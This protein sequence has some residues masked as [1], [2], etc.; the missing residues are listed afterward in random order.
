MSQEIHS[1]RVCVSIYGD[2]LCVC[3]LTDQMVRITQ[4]S[5]QSN[6][7]SVCKRAYLAGEWISSVYQSQKEIL[8][9]YKNQA[10]PHSEL[11]PPLLFV[12]QKW[13]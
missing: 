8:T 5:G 4:P 13:S 6:L 1:K 3:N 7:E 11:E 12:K 10:V 2:S 9:A